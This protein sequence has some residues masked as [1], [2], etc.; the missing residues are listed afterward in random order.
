MLGAGAGA[1]ALAGFGVVQAYDAATAPL[2]APTTQPTPDAYTVAVAA[3][4]GH[5]LSR[6][7]TAVSSPSPAV[8]AA[9]E[10]VVTQT[11][12][13]DGYVARATDRYAAAADASA[14]RIL[15]TGSGT[16]TASLREALLAAEQDL[17]DRTLAAVDPRLARLFAAAAAG[18]AAHAVRLGA[19]D[20]LD[21]PQNGGRDVHQS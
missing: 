13:W 5:R 14:A 10:A 15:P 2:P 11:A 1:V 7:F 6:R 21:G 4:V 20:G 18:L 17:L 12:L 19:P 3:A 8:S 16:D 9:R